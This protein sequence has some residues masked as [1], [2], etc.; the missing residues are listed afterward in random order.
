M[1][2]IPAPPKEEEHVNEKNFG[3]FENR[4]LTESE[5][6]SRK[7]IL[8]KW[9]VK[10]KDQFTEEELE[11][12]YQLYKP[13]PPKVYDLDTP[14]SFSTNTGYTPREIIER[15]PEWLLWALSNYSTFVVQ[16]AVMGALR[17]R[18]DEIKAKRQLRVE[19]TYGA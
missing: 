17:M 13:K 19:S 16:D 15:N 7:I 11:E 5:L 8:E 12:I 1:R 2:T 6:V 3:P 9:P 14:L 18:L 10:T 4:G